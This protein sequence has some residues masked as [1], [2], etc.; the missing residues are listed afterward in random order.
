MS[1]PRVNFYVILENP[2]TTDQYNA[3][4]QNSSTC[5]HCVDGSKVVLKFNVDNG[6][7]SVFSGMVVYNE[8]EVKGIMEGLDWTQD[9]T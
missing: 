3:A 1:Q 5:R 9:E 2:V 7:P 6:F 8:S 4:I